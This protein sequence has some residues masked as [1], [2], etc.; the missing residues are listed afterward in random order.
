M[1]DVIDVADAHWDMA[2]QSRGQT[3]V[4]D[5]AQFEIGEDAVSTDR[6][7]CTH[8]LCVSA[9]EAILKRKAIAML[10]ATMISTKAVY[11][12]PPSRDLRL[13]CSKGSP[14]NLQSIGLPRS[15]PK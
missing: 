14:L 10:S 13:H 15:Q 6:F 2:K 12:S 4:V 3:C 1:L 8:A 9:A 11:P 5:P 7:S